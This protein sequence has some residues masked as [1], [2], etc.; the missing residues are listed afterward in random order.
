[1]R[2]LAF[3]DVYRWNGYKRLVER[4]KP[5]VV[6]LAGDLTSDGN[7]QFWTA[8]LEYVPEY[9]KKIEALKRE[10]IRCLF[11]EN[12]AALAQARERGEKAILAR[13]GPA[14]REVTDRLRE[15]THRARKETAYLAAR[16]R[17]HVN[18][19]YDFL[20]YAGR[21]S[22]VLVVKGDHDDDFPGDYDP[23]RIDGI[24]GCHE[25][26]GKTY[27]FGEWVFLGLGFQQV[28]YRRPLR[29]FIA[30]LRG[31]VGIVIAHVPEKN[32]R[33]VTELR[34]NLLIRGHFGYGRHVID[35]VAAAFT[36]NAYAIIEIGTTGSPRIQ[37][38]EEISWSQ[39]KRSGR[40]RRLPDYNEAN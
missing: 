25:I 9:K 38:C 28:G 35:G 12:E 2:I 18:R 14:T 6:A 4:Y 15:L 40:I 34:P 17:M 5:Q 22:T 8:A 11:R 20:R 24:P 36:S 1:M 37:G 30:D 10:R 27:V 19:F 13:P 7:A 16:Q 31:R 32:L 21:A 23:S 33:L 39:L 26:S 3:S 29:R